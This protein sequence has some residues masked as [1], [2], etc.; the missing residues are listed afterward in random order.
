MLANIYSDV[1]QEHAGELRERLR[2][3]G[4]FAFSGCPTH[5]SEITRSAIER[6]GLE[7]ERE[8]RRGRWH[9]FLGRRV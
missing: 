7:L 6:A 9:T 2:P 5:H 8:H 4:W 3:G 1:I